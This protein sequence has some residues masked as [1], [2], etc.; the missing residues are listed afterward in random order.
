MTR[1]LILA[2]FDDEIF[3]CGFQYGFCGAILLCLTIIGINCIFE[4]II[5]MH[6]KIKEKR[7]EK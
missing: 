1:E 3:Q 4:F 7:N 6:K 5:E 2:L